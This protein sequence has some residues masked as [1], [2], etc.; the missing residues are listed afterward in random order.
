M[1]SYLNLGGKSNIAAYDIG[2]DYINVQFK[3]NSIYLYTYSSAGMQSIEQMKRLAT[4]GRGLN[5][6]IN[7][8]VK[9][10]YASKLR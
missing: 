10:L 4:Q 1:Q 5:S 9:R 2:S 6:F 3:D 7:T 8:E